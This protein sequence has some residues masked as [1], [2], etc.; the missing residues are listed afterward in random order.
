MRE[1]SAQSDYAPEWWAVM[2]ALSVSVGCIAAMTLLCRKAIGRTVALAAMLAVAAC[3]FI[4]HYC[5]YV[6]EVVE[7]AEVVKCELHHEL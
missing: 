5:A 2:A 7:C 6:V 3:G 4:A 1:R